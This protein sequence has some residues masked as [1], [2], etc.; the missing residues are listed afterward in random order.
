MAS[1]NT[2][3]KG[4]FY[5]N[6]S[7]GNNLSN[8]AGLVNDYSTAK[9]D[10]N[11]LGDRPILDDPS[12]YYASIVRFD[13]PGFNIPMAYN[14]IQTPFNDPNKTI[15]SF[16]ITNNS[17]N[18]THTSGQV[19][20]T[21]KPEYV[22]FSPSDIPVAT[23]GDTQ[24]AL[25]YYYQYSIQH[26]LDGWNDALFQ[27][28]AN[29]NASAGTHFNAPYFDFN[30]S[31]QLISIYTDEGD[32]GT[33]E[34]ADPRVFY[35]NYNLLK[36]MV[37]LRAVGNFGLAKADGTD[38]LITISDPHRLRRVQVGSLTKIRTDFEFNAYGYFS[39]I[40]SIL[41]TTAMPVESEIF[42]VDNPRQSNQNLNYLQI[43]TDYIPDLSQQNGM[44]LNQQIFN[45][46]AS[47][48]WRVFTF[49]QK[50]PLYSISLNINVLDNYN[51]VVPLVLEKGTQANF[52]IMFIRKDIYNGGNFM[53][54]RIG[55]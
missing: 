24:P 22:N 17:A 28:N 27:A 53:T 47:S 31:T 48:V 16:T 14:L 1:I 19:F 40:K 30:A 46:N 44:G 45:Y 7:V 49:T 35:Y 10:V 50:T 25:P 4:I 43:L 32:F 33:L 52:K 2:K 34:T 11:A 55:I 5:Y 20:V 54:N 29:Y 12:N 37:G 6:L 21:H 38:V 13:V 18:P 15:Y 26:I 39:W 3:D 8:E 42:F 23:G 41:I 9:A 36:R 51:N